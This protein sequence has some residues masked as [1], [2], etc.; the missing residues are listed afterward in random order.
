MKRR[1]KL[2]E[3]YLHRVIKESVKQVL[4]EARKPSDK[5]IG[6]HTFPTKLHE[7]RDYDFYN[8]WLT[9]DASH[10]K[11]KYDINGYHVEIDNMYCVLIDNGM[12]EYFLQ[13]DEADD[14]IYDMCLEWENNPNMS[15][16][17]IIYA[18]IQQY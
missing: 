7:E 18:F 5:I 9:G 16:E 17:E 14:L 10:F 1:I 8:P 12:D 4:K 6:R 2:T 11:G 13:G 15:K 3:S